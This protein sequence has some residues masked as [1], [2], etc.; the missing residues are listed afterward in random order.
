MSDSR[1]GL[2]R[3]SSAIAI[4]AGAGVLSG[5]LVDATMAAIFGAGARTDAFFIASTIPFA[6]A[7]LLLASTN[8]VLVP[9]VN[10]WFRTSEERVALDRIWNLLGT[11]L[12]IGAVTAA[13]GILLA[14]V[15]PSVIAPGAA[16]ATQRAAATMTALLFITVVTRIGAEILR[17][18]LNARF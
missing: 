6:L 3:S 5:F 11:G 13:V 10:G 16:T 2:A 7:S 15:I 8:Q 18:T 4:F 1:R 17:A 14:R 9:L 12:A